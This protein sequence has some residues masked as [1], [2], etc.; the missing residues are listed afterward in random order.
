MPKSVF[1]LQKIAIIKLYKNLN[2]EKSKMQTICIANCTLFCQKVLSYGKRL[3]NQLFLA[4]T[5]FSGF[6]I[7]FLLLREKVRKH[8]GFQIIIICIK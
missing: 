5:F 7:G 1:Y 2:G 4:K 8:Q 3:V 6:Y